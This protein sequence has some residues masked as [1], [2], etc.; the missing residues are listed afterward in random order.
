ME[1]FAKDIQ[2][3]LIKTIDTDNKWVATSSIKVDI[4]L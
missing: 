2:K 3:L 1:Q 4:S